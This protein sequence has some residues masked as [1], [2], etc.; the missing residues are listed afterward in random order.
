MKIA[1]IL[2]E[3]H[4]ASQVLNYTKSQHSGF[5]QDYAITN[6][7]KWTK[8]QQP[9]SKLKIPDEN[10]RGENP[11]GT[12]NPI[13]LDRANAITKDEILDNPIVVDRQGWIIDGNHRAYKARQLDMK[14]IPA[15]I[16]VDQ[17]SEPQPEYHT[18]RAVIQGLYY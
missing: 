3:T 6:H 16:P 17:Y 18:G 11:Y 8:F 10:G 14:T 13:D 1:D 15:F 4:Q 5:N 12:N 7:P 2:L 9:V